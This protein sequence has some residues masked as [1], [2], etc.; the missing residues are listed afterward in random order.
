VA[1]INIA[2]HPDIFKGDIIIFNFILS[3]FFGSIDEI[4]AMRLFGFDSG[5]GG[6]CGGC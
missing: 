4:N 6:G 2:L 5:C 3:P 1:V